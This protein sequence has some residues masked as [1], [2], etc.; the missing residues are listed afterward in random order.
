MDVIDRL[1][2]FN[3][4][5][6]RRLGLLRQGYLEAGLSLAEARVI[7]ELA[8]GIGWTAGALSRH[9]GLN[10][11]YLSRMLKRLQN[12]GL[13]ERVRD[14]KDRRVHRLGLTRDGLIRAAE[15]TALSREQ[16]GAWIAEMPE[17]EAEG[18]ANGL[19]RAEARLSGRPESF[20][21]IELRDLAIG[22]AGWLIEQHALL[23]ARDEGF[24]ASF[25]ALVAEILAAYIRDR[26]PA[27]ERA[28]IAWSKGRRLGS[29]FCVE[30]PAPDVAKLRLFL[31]VPEARGLGLG[32]RLLTECLDF[33]R[34]SGYRRLVLWTHESHEAACAL[35][36]KAGFRLDSAKPVI[37]FSVD[38]IEQQWSIDL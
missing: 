1:R 24:D 14:P 16:V 18:I 4:A 36:R 17:E 29:I 10:E 34:A 11:G 32:Q 13:V 25:E 26:N 38:L 28:W 31:L 7:F 23:Y 9:L 8:D 12:A 6:T 35:Y 30:G 19:E 27:R 15:L 5:H 22:D 3:R 33:A 37:S 20:D 2:A 21:E